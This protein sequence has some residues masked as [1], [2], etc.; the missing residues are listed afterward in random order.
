MFSD[1][2]IC[3]FI[4]TLLYSERSNYPCIVVLYHSDWLLCSPLSV[5]I[6]C[7]SRKRWPQLICLWVS[8]CMKCIWHPHVLVCLKFPAW[9]PSQFAISCYC[10]AEFLHCSSMPAVMKWTLPSISLLNISLHGLNPTILIFGAFLDESSLFFKFYQ[11]EQSWA[12]T[13][14]FT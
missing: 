12:N 7:R 2:C 10:M 3:I 14:L 6:Y 4:M 13:N 11:Y 5:L 1:F 8:Y 9:N